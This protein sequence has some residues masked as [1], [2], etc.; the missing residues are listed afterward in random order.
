[1]PER[2][3]YD[4]AI[5]LAQTRLKVQDPDLKYGQ[6]ET[7]TIQTNAG[8][9]KRLWGSQGGFAVVY[10]FRTQSGKMRA[11]RC[12]LVQ[13]NQDIQMRYER[14]GTYFA[15]HASNI[16]VEFRYYNAGI[17]LKENVYGQ[18]QSKTYPF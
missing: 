11:I 5:L 16:T 18:P 15:V 3:A 1:M 7:I 4:E 8:A 9:M 2:M 10:K 13:M 6:V 14:I 12:F 17:V